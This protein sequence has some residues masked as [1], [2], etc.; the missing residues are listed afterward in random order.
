MGIPFIETSAKTGDNV[1]LAFETL[2]RNTPRPGQEYKVTNSTISTCLF[3]YSLTHQHI[4]QCAYCQ[5]IVNNILL[6]VV[7]LGSGGVGKSSTTTRFVSNTFVDSYDPTIE[8]SFRKF[9]RVEGIPEE[10]KKG[11][12]SQHVT[13]ESAKI[14]AASPKAK[15]MFNVLTNF[16]RHVFL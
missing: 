8:D 1:Q 3:K 4:M 11:I 7:M 14:A 5:V 13:D 16:T 2:I 12:K 6:Q 9:I 15:C 10:L